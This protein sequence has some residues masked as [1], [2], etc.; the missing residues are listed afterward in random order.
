MNQ[1]PYLSCTFIRREILGLE[2]AGLTVHRFSIRYPE[3]ELI[4]Q[5]DKQEVDQTRYILREGFVRLLL[6]FLQVILT[7]PIKFAAALGQAIRLGM[8]S[9]RGVLFHLAY[10]LEACTLFLW[11]KQDPVEQVHCH[12]ATNS[13]TIAMLCHTLGG[14]AYSFTVHGPHEFDDVEGL[15]LPEKIVQSAFVLTISSFSKS[16]LFRWCGYE[17]WSKIHEIHCGV[18][19]TFLEESYSLP[20]NQRQFVCVGRLSEQKGH[21]ILLEAAHQLA[22]EGLEFKILLVGD[23][24]FRGELES[25]IDQK[26]LGNYVEITGWATNQQVQQYMKASQILVQPSFAEGLPVVIMEALALG[27]PTLTT[28]IAGIP[29]LVKPGETG[30][31]VPAGSVPDLVT[32]MRSILNTPSEDLVVMGKM[33][34]EAVAERHN[35]WTEASKLAVL[36]DQAAQDRASA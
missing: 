23:G 9:S 1:H 13:T 29:E 33:G 8:K 12:F 36:F 34:M 18:D 31:L 35:A 5:A 20:A 19:D 26:D 28:Y 4:D 11:L 3:I 30:W 27:R 2:Q 25:I 22:Q 7:H 15:S 17:H 32:A 6:N 10:L 16:Q 24:P 14:P 21:F